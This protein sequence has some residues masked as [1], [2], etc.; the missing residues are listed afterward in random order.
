MLLIYTHISVKR[1]KH[2]N[3]DI[4]RL[5]VREWKILSKYAGLND[6]GSFNV[7]SIVGYGVNVLFDDKY[8]QGYR[9]FTAN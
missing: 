7:F 4:C 3:A 2:A 1:Y 6:T 5:Q 8:F 9:Q